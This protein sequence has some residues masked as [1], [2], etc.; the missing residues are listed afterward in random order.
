[1][2]DQFVPNFSWYHPTRIVYGVGKLQE[3][4]VELSNLVEPGSSVF[5]VTGRTSLKARGILQKV[6]D[7]LSDY[8]V[9]IF[10]DVRPFPSPAN[11]DSAVEA[12]KASN[13][14]IVVAIGGGSAMDLAKAVAILAVHDGSALEYATNEREFSLKGLPFIAAPTTSGSS[15]EVTSGSAL[16][17]LEGKK[18]YGLS[19]PNMFPEVAIVDPDLTMSMTTSLAANT[20]MDAF[21]SAF[22]SYWNRESNPISDAID[23]DVIRTFATNLERS[24]IQ[25]DMESRAACALAASMSGAAYS[26]SR[27]NACH[28]VGGPLTLYWGIE[29]GQAVGITLGGFLKHA[30]PAIAHK[31]NA[32]WNALQV[33][34]VDGAVRRITQI[35]SRCGLETTLSGLGLTKA[36]IDT[37]V[38]NTI[39]ARIDPLPAPMDRGQLKEMLTS[40]Y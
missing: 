34:D 30:A 18:H 22:E 36:D 38:D 15:S 5:L 39:W 7:G 14:K 20:G 13:A 27:P 17:D 25:G 24:A 35:M 33:D 40:I 26:N 21:T 19:G 28:A 9:T 37:I 12:C 3:L 32:L 16:W 11:V 1:M 2:Q 29:H 31:T 10:N 6:L 23:L 8:K 4:P